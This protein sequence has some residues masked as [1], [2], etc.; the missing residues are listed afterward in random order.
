MSKCVWL[1]AYIHIYIYIYVY[2]VMHVYMYVFIVGR[3]WASSHCASRFFRGATGPE[4][5]KHIHASC[6]YSEV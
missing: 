6:D 5:H 4:A 2:G 3:G 1:G